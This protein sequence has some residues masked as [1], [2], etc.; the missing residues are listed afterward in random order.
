MF[1]RKAAALQHLFGEGLL[2]QFTAEVAPIKN[3]LVVVKQYASSFF[4]TSVASTL[5]A[6]VWTP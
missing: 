4:G 3:E 5:N 2:S 1:L 6:P